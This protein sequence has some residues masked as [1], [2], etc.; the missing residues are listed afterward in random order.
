[1]GKNSPT[2]S[3]SLTK[4]SVTKKKPVAKSKKSTVKDFDIDDGMSEL[5]LALEKKKCFPLTENDVQLRFA[6]KPKQHTLTRE[7][8]KKE[9]ES[10]SRGYQATVI[11]GQYECGTGICVDPNGSILTC[12]HCL[13]DYPATEIQKYVIFPSGLIVLTKCV[14]V[15]IKADIALLD[16]VSYYDD[17]TRMMRRAKLSRPF[18]FVDIG[19]SLTLGETLVCFGQPGRDD[20]ESAVKRKTGYDIFMRSRGVY[21]GSLEG[22]LHDN[23]EIGKLQHN[24]WTY[25]GHSGAPLLNKDCKVIGLHSSWDDEEGTRH[26]IHLTAIDRFLKKV[27]DTSSLV[28]EKTKRKGK[29]QNE[30]KMSKKTS[31]AREIEVVDLISP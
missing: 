31:K 12:A 30:E 19:D 14:R 26:G 10:M 20:L 5:S 8:K 29:D 3:S 24:C 6:Y 28:S 15:D 22:D 7:Y 17:E 23:N 1:M 13:G 4:K 21:E 9:T 11:F 27:A 25:W 2:K 18:P 16:V